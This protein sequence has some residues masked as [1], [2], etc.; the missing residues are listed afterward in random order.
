[1]LYIDRESINLMGIF[2]ESKLKVRSEHISK[3]ELERSLVK[4][5]GHFVNDIKTKD[6][7]GN[8][9]EEF[10]KWEFIYSLIDSDLYKHDL[11]GT[12]VYFPK[13]NKNSQPI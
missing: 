11:I 2:A 4:Y 10:Y 6:I 7:N 3:D 13:G 5:N 9:N 1:M 8:P 12:E